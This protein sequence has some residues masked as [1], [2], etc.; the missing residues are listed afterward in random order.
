M[1][2]ND[3]TNY[4]DYL[5]TGI[6]VTALV[7]DQ[8]NRKW[9]GTFGSGVYLAS[10][11][12]SEVLEHFTADNSPLLSDNIYSLAIHPETGELMIGTDV[13]LCSYRTNITPVQPELVEDNVKVY[14]NP[15]RPAYSGNV[16]ITGLTEEAEVKIVSAGSQLVARGTAVGGSFVWDVRSQTTGQRVA[17]GVYFILVANADGSE[18]VAANVVVI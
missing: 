6:D 2:R 16:T 5:L 9:L 18:S 10:P 15:V 13:G 4:A 12:G 14:P 1:P 8:G 7:V 11:D 17:P 3:G